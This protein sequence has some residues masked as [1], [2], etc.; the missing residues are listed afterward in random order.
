MIKI[1]EIYLKN[2]KFHQIVKV[3]Q[4][5]DCKISINF[6]KKISIEAKKL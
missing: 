3:K 6:R 2:K 4:V 5:D 1:R